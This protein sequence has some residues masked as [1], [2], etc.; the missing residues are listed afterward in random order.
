M[1]IVRSDQLDDKRQDNERNLTALGYSAL[2]H[3]VSLSHLGRRLS[4]LIYHRVLPQS[5]PLF[6]DEVDAVSFDR[7][8][9]QIGQSFNIIPLGQ[10]VRSLRNG[11]LPAGAACITFDDGYADNA[12]IALPILQRHGVAATFFVAT[13]FLNGGRMWNDTVIE[14]VRHAPEG[15]LDATGL[16]LGVHALD[17]IGQRQQA[18]SALIGQL[19][20]LPPDERLAQVDG[21]VALVGIDLPSDLM[22]TTDQVRQLHRAG[23]E[24]GGH[25]VTHPILARV[26]ASHAR[27]EIV[28][29]KHALEEIT[30]EPIRLFAYPNGKPGQ[31]YLAEHVAMVKQVGFDAAV[32]TSWGASTTSSD[33]FQLAR[34]TP[35]DKGQ[36]RFTLRLLRNL[37]KTGRTA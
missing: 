14:L 31:D 22:M 29:G 6:P 17:T 25:T 19:K 1:P 30:G 3:I 16:G 37:G 13:G 32:S 7:Q 10:A 23:M 26:S 21:L 33:L 15:A 36:L 8:L 2:K 24:I 35:W 18:I 27:Q 12:D 34:F 20:Y 5:D 9:T 28:D 11:T 4:I